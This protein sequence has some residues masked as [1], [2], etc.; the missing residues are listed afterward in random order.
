MNVD[1]LR[2]RLM[3]DPYDRAPD[4]EQAKNETLEHRRVARECEQFE[5][6]LQASLQ[7]SSGAPGVEEVMQALPGPTAASRSWMAI[8]A[9]VAVAALLGLILARPLGTD[10]TR[11]A[12]VAHFHYDEPGALESDQPLEPDQAISLLAE[13]DA[14]IADSMRVTYAQRCVIGGR[15]GLHLVLTGDNDEK[16]SVLFMPTG[17]EVQEGMIEVD[18]AQARLVDVT[19]GAVGVFVH[20][21]QS[22]DD[23]VDALFSSANALGHIARW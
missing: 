11:D 13:V 23:T 6:R 19:G 3:T 15:Q 12:L 14:H 8:A 17:E 10:S 18:G 16:T 21:N 22:L 2:Q 20:G 4:V 5:D 1:E 9:S 7:A